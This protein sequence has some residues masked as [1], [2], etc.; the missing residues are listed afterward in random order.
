MREGTGIYHILRETFRGTMNQK[1]TLIMA[2]FYGIGE[3][4]EGHLKKG[5]GTC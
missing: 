2:V 3:R 5:E 1:I 4:E